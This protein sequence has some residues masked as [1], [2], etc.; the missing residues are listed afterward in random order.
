MK[1]LFVYTTAF[2]KSN[3]VQKKVAEQIAHLNTATSTCKGIFIVDRD[4]PNTRFSEHIDFY[5]IPAGTWKFFR[6]IEHRRERIKYL[7]KIVKE[8]GEQYDYILM[9]YPYASFSLYFF[10]LFRKKNFIIEHLTDE[11]AEIK[12]YRQQNKFSFS[13]TSILSYFEGMWYPMF[14]EF[15]LRRAINQRAKLLLF[16]STEIANRQMHRIDK[17][18]FMIGGDAVNVEQF[19]LK[20]VVP[21]TDTINLVFLKGSST[22]ADFN[23]LDRIVKSILDYKGKYKIVLHVLGNN[24]VYENSLLP[25]NDDRFVLKK[26]LYEAELDDFFESMHL[27]ISTLG[28][29]R[30]NLSNSTTIK[31]REYFARGI[32]FVYAY[33]D[34]DLELYPETKKYTLQ[35]PNDDSPIA[36][37]NIVAFA[38]NQYANPNHNKEM[39]Q[40]ATEFLSYK[41]KMQK[42]INFISKHQNI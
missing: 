15:F 8:K 18:K 33:E 41:V 27:G 37:D 11:L 7:R 9:R 38:L 29:F 34:V 42:V 28:L 24:L 3:S 5:Q 6:H 16:N 35:F 21:I 14:K 40:L 1:L 39:R 20:Q 4:V 30:K 12:L 22:A 36:M 10:M 25:Q 31:T 13:P 17:A 19:K 2:P 23:G 32:P 26:A